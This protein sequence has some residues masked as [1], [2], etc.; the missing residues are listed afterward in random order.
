MSVTGII[1]E[2]NPFHNGHKYNCNMAKK[3]TGSDCIISVMSGNFLQR[4]EP[5]L[6]DKW[7]RSKMAILEGVDLVIE[8][9]VIYSCQ[10]AENFAY[11]AVKILNSL[12]IV[13]YLCFGSES[14][15]IDE[16]M[17]VTNILINEPEYFRNHVQKN[18]LEGI[19]YSKA[20]GDAIN[21]IT[22]AKIAQPN[23]ILGLE[24]LK[25]IRKLKSN[26]EPVTIKRINN[27]YHDTCLTG[28]IS[29]AT[30]I[31]EEI[32]LNGLSDKL[33]K[34]VPKSTFDIMTQSYKYQGSPIFIEDFSDLI[35]YQLRK[36][37]LRDLAVLPHIKEG[38]ENRIKAK[39]N[40]ST[41]LNDL[42]DCVKTKRYTRT[43]LQR[44]LC[45]TLLGM[46]KDDVLH[47]KSSKSIV[48]IRVL[49]LNKKGRVLL[50]KIKA[51]SSYPIINKAA[52][53]KSKDKFLNRM[54]ELDV[55]ATDIYNLVKKNPECKLQKQD[56]LKSPNYMD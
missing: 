55:L 2:Y 14:G 36:S 35:F 44:I 1:S 53:F 37:S 40:T 24:Y 10:P 7:L 6:F 46:T 34:A 54:F 49:A 48:Y 43:Y 32:K 29:G 31:R 56:Y 12:G 52:D 26:I 23:N 4:G 13:D 15:D 3:I 21:S 11:G 19:T 9:P 28:A 51:N 39:S 22:D 18:I 41:T 42:I 38:L 17:K 25:A 5:A 50:K 45:Y 47:S 27:E 16:L 8:L 30:A 33:S 20:I